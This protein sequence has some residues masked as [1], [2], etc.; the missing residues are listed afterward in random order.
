MQCHRRGCEGA[1]RVERDLTIALAIAIAIAMR[2]GAI[3]T[4]SVVL[5]FCARVVVADNGR[6]AERA[7][8]GR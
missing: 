1:Y 7:S 2:C 6:G 5:C 8:E 3:L 4:C